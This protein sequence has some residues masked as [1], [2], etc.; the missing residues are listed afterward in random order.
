M[1]WCEDTSLST[2][3]TGRLL[4]WSCW[5]L[6]CHGLHRSSCCMAYSTV[7]RTNF[8][9]SKG[10][11]SKGLNIES[12]C[13]VNPGPQVQ[14]VAGPSYMWD[15][16]VLRCFTYTFMSLK[17]SFCRSWRWRCCLWRVQYCLW[18]RCWFWFVRSFLVLDRPTTPE[19]SNHVGLGWFWWHLG[20]ILASKT[21][22]EWLCH[23]TLVS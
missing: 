11:K 8:A 17:Q 5:R 1:V 10:R 2:K 16:L 6:Q 22:P 19:I 12:C 9:I 13:Q 21:C 4:V 20:W 3:L 15:C 23:A 7:L 18:V 14:G